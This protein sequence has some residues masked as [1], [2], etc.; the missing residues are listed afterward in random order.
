MESEV[1]RGMSSEALTW[2]RG[3]MLDQLRGAPRMGGL[4]EKTSSQAVHCQF[5]ALP[6]RSI[7]NS[8]QQREAVNLSLTKTSSF[9]AIVSIGKSDLT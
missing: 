8:E 6:Q 4:W 2:R 7:L 9:N 5:G 1:V 3:A